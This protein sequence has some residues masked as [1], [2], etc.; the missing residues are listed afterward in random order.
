MAFASPKIISVMN[1]VKPP[2]NINAFTQGHVLNSLATPE[3]TRK[4]IDKVKQNRRDLAMALDLLPFV[5]TVHPSDANFL[6]V[7]VKDA[8]AVY[9]Y[10]LD[11]GIVVRDRSNVALCEN[12]LRITV[13]NTS[14]NDV[15]ITALKN[16]NA[17]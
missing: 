11:E 9:K 4:S 12:C 17:L 2:Y 13:G 5:V 1:K 10:L 3:L 6:L 7:Q 16:F 14:E 15:L 8:Q